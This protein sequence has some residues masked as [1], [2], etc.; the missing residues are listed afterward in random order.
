MPDQVFA[1]MDETAD[2]RLFGGP[3]SSPLIEGEISLAIVDSHHLFRECLASALAEEE[4]FRIVAVGSNGR[5]VLDSLD[6]RDADVLLLGI[7][8]SADCVAELIE[9]VR[10]RCPGIKT[11]VVGPREVDGQILRCFEAGARGYLFRDQSLG[12]LRSSIL[13]VARGETVCPPRVAHLLFS[14][15]ADLGRARRRRDRLESLHL[16]PRELEILRLIAEDLSNHEIARRLYLS[17][18][19]VKNHIHKVL[20]TLGVESRRQAVRH[21]VEKGWLPDRRRR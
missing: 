4:G 12:E 17:V 13:D 15:L 10:E 16:T 9:G 6:S 14:R 21:A 19:T 20:E 8:S 2:D 3:H 11:L 7:N 5:D 1:T 18:H